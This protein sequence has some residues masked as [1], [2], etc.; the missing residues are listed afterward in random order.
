MDAALAINSQRNYLVRL[1][2]GEAQSPK[3][4]EAHQ[5]AMRKLFKEQE[6]FAAIVRKE[7]GQEPAEFPIRRSEKY[8]KQKGR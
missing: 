5:E 6:V 4:A 3:Q 7:I 2:R 1:L 8:K